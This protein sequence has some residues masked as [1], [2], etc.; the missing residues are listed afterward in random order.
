MW[1]AYALRYARIDCPPQG[2]FLS[3]DPHDAPGGRDYFVWLLRQPGRDILVDTG[4]TPDAARRWK[5][6]LLIPVPDALATMGVD[7]AALRDVVISHLHYDHAGNLNLFPSATFHLQE[8]EMAYATGR[9]M[10]HPVLRHPFDVDDVCCMVR[11]L[12]ADRVRFHRGDATLAP[13]ITLHHLPGHSL[14]LMAVRVA[15]ARGPIV[16]AA[17]VAHYWDNLRLGDHFPVVVD[18]GAGLDSLRRLLALADGDPARIVP[19]H[20]PAVT[21][22]FRRL[23]GVD[24]YALHEPPVAIVPGWPQQRVEGS[25]G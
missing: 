1:E 8:A 14:G 18:L 23:D 11:K 22:V 15:T 6:E 20:D 7:C 10:C 9:L 19:G 12:Y 4:F 17:D 5:R 16:L 13:G 3:G 2:N 24:A 25:R 21:S